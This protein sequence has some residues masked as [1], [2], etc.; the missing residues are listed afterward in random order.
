MRALNR[1]RPLRR[2]LS[3][4]PAGTDLADVAGRATY[5]G[6]PEHKSYPSFAGL[7]RLR[8][9]ASKCDPL[10]KDPHLLTGWLRASIRSG[11]FG[12]WEGSFPKYVWFV[13]K[14]ICYEARLSNR[15]NGDYHGY[16]LML[17]ERPEG[18]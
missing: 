9:D 16:P 1:K 5:I 2:A 14:G 12:S 17:E 6:S 7:P 8:S 3:P 15:E 10:F 4:A 11:T 18:L 13:D